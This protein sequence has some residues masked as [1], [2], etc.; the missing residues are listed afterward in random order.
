[1]FYLIHSYVYI[2]RVF[3]SIATFVNLSSAYSMAVLS[4]LLADYFQT[5]ILIHLTRPFHN[6]HL[7]KQQRV[8]QKKQPIFP[9]EMFAKGMEGRNPS[10]EITNFLLLKAHAAFTVKLSD[11][12]ESVIAELLV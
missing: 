10:S 7:Q 8:S 11:E 3:D 1:M 12:I 4:A 9:F 6:L 2:C 5:L